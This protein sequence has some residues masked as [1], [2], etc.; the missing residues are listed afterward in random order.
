MIR[1]DSYLAASGPD[2]ALSFFVEGGCRYMWFQPVVALE[3]FNGD[4]AGS[5]ITSSLGLN[6]WI[7]K[8]NST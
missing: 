2:E 6:F 1:Y 5:G 3:Y 8:A 7:A 4:A